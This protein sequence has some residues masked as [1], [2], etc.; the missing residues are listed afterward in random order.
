VACDV[1]RRDVLCRVRVRSITA[2]V[3]HGSQVYIIR[4]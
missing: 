2:L 1:G 3:R 4:Y